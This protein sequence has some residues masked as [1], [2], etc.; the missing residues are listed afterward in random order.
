MSSIVSTKFTQ[1]FTGL[2]DPAA[3]AAIRE[4]EAISAEFYGEPGGRAAVLACLKEDARLVAGY[5]KTINWTDVAFPRM[6]GTPREA[7]AALEQEQEAGE[8]RLFEL[9]SELERCGVSLDVLENAADALLIERD[10]MA[11]DTQVEKDNSVFRL[12]GWVRED[13]I[14]KV[15]KALKSVT[16]AY[17]T[18]YRD[19]EEGEVPPTVLKNDA[20][21]T[22][23]ESLITL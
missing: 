1:Y 7:M 11:A 17:Y 6:N 20:F 15:E 9:Q 16:D 21:N 2:V 3:E 14:D 5:L 23:F 19:P 10:N 12:E 13:E 22:P 18:E 4:K 8:K